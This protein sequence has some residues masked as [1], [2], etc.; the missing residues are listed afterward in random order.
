MSVKPEGVESAGV[1]PAPTPRRG[2]LP[3]VARGILV[4]FAFAAI[5]GCVSGVAWHAVVRPPA[6]TVGTGGV[7][8]TSEAEL[9]RVFSIDAWYVAGGIIGGIVLGLLA[10]WLF[11]RLGWIVPF[12]ALIA[13]QIAGFVT[14]GVGAA[15]G[16]RNFDERMS[17]A[18]QGQTLAMDFTLRSHSGVLVWSIFA[19]L[20]V[21]LFSALGRDEDDP[22]IAAADRT[23]GGRMLHRLAG[24]EPGLPEPESLDDEDDEDAAW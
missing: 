12:L 8:T 11:R 16:P 7:A 17:A 23:A 19:V 24:T 1:T 3:P 6:Y 15:L 14:W 2:L 10:W 18:Q 5:W 13:S 4:F 22:L 21:L 9:A 20:P